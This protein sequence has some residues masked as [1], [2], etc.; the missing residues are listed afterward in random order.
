VGQQV[1]GTAAPVSQT[2]TGTYSIDAGGF[3]TLDNPIRS[4]AKLNA[5]YSS[6]A[7]LGSSTE[8]ADSAFDL[9]VAIPAPTGQAV[10]GGPYNAV[11]LEFPG[12]ATAN[13]RAC[14]FSINALPLGQ[15]S[16][17]TV[18][19]HAANIKSGLPQTPQNING[20]TFTMAA[21][22]TGT[23]TVGATNSAVL[24]SG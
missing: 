3:V 10:L 19:G 12:A 2:G 14:Q 11:D 17:L 18:N 20:G 1:S 13:M 15:L 5:R 4:G 24:L 23:I 22:G 16:A 6:E 8:S 7:V 21:D 9:F